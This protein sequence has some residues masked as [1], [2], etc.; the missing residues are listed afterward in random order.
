MMKENGADYVRSMVLW[1]DIVKT[2]F[3]MISET[4][5]VFGKGNLPKTIKIYQ[6]INCFD[7]VIIGGVSEETKNS[8][9]LHVRCNCMDLKLRR[10]AV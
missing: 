4:V 1:Q 8:F 10:F 5:A 9:C 3:Y 6:I 2:E 7:D